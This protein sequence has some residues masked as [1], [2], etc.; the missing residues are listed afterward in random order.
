MYDANRKLRPAYRTDWLARHTA[1]ERAAM[2]RRG[3]LASFCAHCGIE[4]EVES[5]ERTDRA[6]TR[7]IKRFLFCFDGEVVSWEPFSAALAFEMRGTQT[8]RHSVVGVKNALLRHFKVKQ[9]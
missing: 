7:S 6:G 3:E 9:F 5:V 2:K 4:M 8:K 1:R